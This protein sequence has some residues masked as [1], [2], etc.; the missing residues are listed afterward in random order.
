MIRGKGQS[1]TRSVATGISFQRGSGASQRKYRYEMWLPNNRQS[2]FA[3]R[4]GSWE[5]LREIQGRKVIRMDLERIREAHDKVAK[6]EMG[7]LGIVQEI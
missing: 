1:D 6:D 4:N 7:C 3:M 5:Q 2:Y